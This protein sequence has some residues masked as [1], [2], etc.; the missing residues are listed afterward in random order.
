MS[1]RFLG[2]STATLAASALLLAGCVK[3]KDTFAVKPDGSGTAKLVATLDLTMVNQLKEMLGGMGGDTGEMDVDKE[4]NPDE[5]RRRLEGKEGIKI[6]SVTTVEDKEK[7]T[8]THTLE[9]EFASLELLFKSG[10]VKEMNVTL[11]KDAEGNYTLTRALGGDQIPQ[12]AEGLEQLQAMMMMFEPFMGKLEVSSTLTFP[13]AILET[14]GTKEGENQVTWSLTF[15]DIGKADK[16]RQ[17]VKFS[18]QGVTMKPF[19]VTAS[20]MDAARAEAEGEG[21]GEEEG[22]PEEE[23]EPAM[24]GGR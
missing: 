15:K 11:E 5:V 18:G 17:V 13:G 24:P 9:L 14:N 19:A 6:V 23:E 16:M 22:A 2:L 21:E 12:D 8:L 20:E 3:S 7:N 1:T 10:A 4:M